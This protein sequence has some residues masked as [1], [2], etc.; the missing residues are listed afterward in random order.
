MIAGYDGQPIPMAYPQ[1][2][3]TNRLRCRASSSAST[4]KSGP[5]R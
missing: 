4:W 2:L 5:R 1:L 3:L